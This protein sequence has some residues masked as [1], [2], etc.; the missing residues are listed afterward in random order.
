MGQVGRNAWDPVKGSSSDRSVCGLQRAV[1]S[2]CKVH[3]AKWIPSSNI[4][5][6][7]SDKKLSF[8]AISNLSSFQYLNT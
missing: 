1:F 3:V 5:V 7:R 6:Q 2:R 8:M 4:L